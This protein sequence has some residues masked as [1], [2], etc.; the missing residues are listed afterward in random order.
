MS[1]LTTQRFLLFFRLFLVIRVFSTMKSASSIKH[2]TTMLT[3]EVITFLLEAILTST[4]R[5]L[6]DHAA[7]AAGVAS[8]SAAPRTDALAAL[9]SHEAVHG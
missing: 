1:M 9:G 6:H 5:A 2:S 8:L 3:M 4:T 7:T